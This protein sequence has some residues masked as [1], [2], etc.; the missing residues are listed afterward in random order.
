MNQREAAMKITREMTRNGV[1][2]IDQ[3]PEVRKHLEWAYAIG[4]DHGRKRSKRL[5]PVIKYS[6]DGR[7]IAA[8]ESVAVAARQNGVSH[9]QIS[10][11]ASGIRQT[12]A[13]HKWK[14][15]DEKDKGT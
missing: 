4:F 9:T 3:E 1:I 6:K 12:A 11:A 14:Y 15:A 13:G 2:D 8:Y 5:R 7:R 10:K